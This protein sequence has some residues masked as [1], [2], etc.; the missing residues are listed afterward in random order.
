MTQRYFER[1]G[2]YLKKSRV[3]ATLSQ[4]TVASA[5]RYDQ[6]FISSWERGLSAPPVRVLR[7]IAG[8]YGV[9]LEELYDLLIEDSIRRTR[10]QLEDEIR[11]ATK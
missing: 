1:F 10:M 9:P 8:H 7:K 4:A 5:L 2:G 3:A 11:K 6:Q